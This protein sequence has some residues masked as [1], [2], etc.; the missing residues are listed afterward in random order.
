MSRCWTELSSER[1]DELRKRLLE[2]LTSYQVIV[3]LCLFSC[4][5]VFFLGPKDCANSDLCGRVR[6]GHPLGARAL[7]STNQRPHLNVSAPAC[8]WAGEADNNNSRPDMIDGNYSNSTG[9]TSHS[10]PGASDSD[11][12]GVLNTSSLLSG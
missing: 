10:S 8:Q 4:Y 1:Y 6:P 9:P 11:T 3:L 12:R 2:L 5:D 7:A